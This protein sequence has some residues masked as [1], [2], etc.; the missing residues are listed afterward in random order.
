MLAILGCAG[1]LLNLT[2]FG[3]IFE[4]STIDELVKGQGLW[5]QC[6]FV[7][8]GALLTAVGFSRQAVGF[9]GGYAFGFAHGVGIS[10][11]AA[12]L[13][14]CLTFCYA[15]YFGREIIAR[16]F[17]ERIQ[18][19]DIFLRDNP[20]T[21]TLLIRFLPVGS[22][23]LTNLAA[24]VSS[25]SGIVFVTASAFG[26]IPQMFIF[27]LLGSGV[28][29]DFW[30][31]IGLSVILFVVSGLIGIHL[32]RKIRIGKHFDALTIRDLDGES[33]EAV[34]STSETK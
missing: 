11:I 17:S 10:I 8:A 6:I 23:V 24:G 22:N 1:V 5:G 4:Q 21:M 30:Y 20:F 9:M 29:L 27:S 28:H 12:V 16:R 14:C 13:G 25:V 34:S 18:R 26:Y 32:Y 2:P 15:R 31:N 19:I 3:S 7:I 33:G